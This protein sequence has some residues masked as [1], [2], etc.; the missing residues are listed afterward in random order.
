AS[1]IAVKY[2]P[3]LEVSAIRQGIAGL[4]FVLFFLIKGEKLPTRK[5][6]TWLAGMGVLLFV[7]ANGFATI[8][9]QYISS[10]LGALI[11]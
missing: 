9:L 10:G 5:Q 7:L 2:T 1:K 8:G 11:S 6:F 4:I 3:A